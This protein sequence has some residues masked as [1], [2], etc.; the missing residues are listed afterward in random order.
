MNKEELL[1]KTIKL[2]YGEN[3]PLF[4]GIYIIQQRKLHD[5]G[6]RMM[7]VI[8]HTEYDKEIEDF[9]YYLI[10]ACSD[11]INLQPAFEKMLKGEYNICDFN[12]DINR[13]GL[14]HIWTNSPKKIKCDFP[15]V[16]SCTFEVV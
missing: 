8:G 6:Y 1:K 16:S 10:S 2:E 9:K 13:N 7:Y 3:M 15:W 14:I 12:L 4:K 11:V 5:S